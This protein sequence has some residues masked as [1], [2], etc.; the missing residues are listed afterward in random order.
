MHSLAID[1][2]KYLIALPV[3]ASL[4]LLWKLDRKTRWQYLYLLV[5]GGI[6]S[7]IIAKIAGKL[8]SDPRPFVKDGI[9][10]LFYSARNN[11]FPSDHTL[12]SAF[13]GFATLPYSRKIGF[14]L[15][16]IAGLIGW[17]R[18]YSGVH[19][20]VDVLGSFAITAV[21]AWLVYLAIKKYGQQ[22]HIL[23]KTSDKA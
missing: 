7:L 8:Y 4:Y 12:L 19:H 17:A 1:I 16:I 9:T 21:S 11:G 23:K 18:V 15:L 6:A 2:A 22:T 10:P 14:S 20:F 3:L 5:I 13:I